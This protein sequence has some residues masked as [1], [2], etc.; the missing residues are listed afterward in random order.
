[1]KT[2]KVCKI[3]G[4]EKEISK[5]PKNRLSCKVCYNKKISEN[6]EAV[7]NRK[8]YRKRYRELNKDTLNNNDRI[9][10]QSVKDTKEHKEKRQKWRDSN[11]E[12]TKDYNSKLNGIRYDKYCK[13]NR[14]SINEYKRERYKNDPTF[15]LSC[16]MR[17]LIRYSFNRLCIKKEINDRTKEI[18]GCSYNDLK[19]HIESKFENWMNWENHGLYNGEL[20]YGWDIDH[21]IPIS[22]AKTK[23][24]II[25]LNHYSNLQ[26][27][28][29][30]I[31]RCVKRNI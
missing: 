13:N 30:Y 27:L 3:C 5:F 28:C 31:N 18:I 25:K 22:S 2:H 14:D 10:Y 4:S 11:K 1:M 15:R 9:Y 26:P 21:I 8:E 12:Y 24:D 29:S 19:K 17:G 6:K 16:N 20:N 23:D 7:N